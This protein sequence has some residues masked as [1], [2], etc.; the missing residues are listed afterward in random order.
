M[1][2]IYDLVETKVFTTLRD[3]ISLR[4]DRV[5]LRG[6]G[7]AIN[8][9]IIAK[10]E[11]CLCYQ[12]NVLIT[13]S[14]STKKV[15]RS[16]FSRLLC[17]RLA[18]HLACMNEGKLGAEQMKEY[19]AEGNFDEYAYNDIVEYAREMEKTLHRVAAALRDLYREKA[20]NA[21]NAA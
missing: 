13:A 18:S 20:E 4:L 15:T 9:K 21:A 7:Y 3:D 16:A 12:D 6:G 19:A 2:S 10:G 11:N 5:E 8:A 14:Y 1:N 17:D